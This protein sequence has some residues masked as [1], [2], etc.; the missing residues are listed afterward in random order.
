MAT[1]H[2]HEHEDPSVHS[3]LLA[4]RKTIHGYHLAMFGMAEHRYQVLLKYNLPTD[5]INTY[6]MDAQA[7]PESFYAVRNT[8]PMLLPPVGDGTLT[9]YPARLDRVTQTGNGEDRVFEPIKEG[10]T[11][12]IKEVLNFRRF[13]QEDF[14][15]HLTYLI[16]GEGDEAHIAHR[17][18][19]RP[20]FEQIIT[21]RH[22]PDGLTQD[23]LSRAVEVTIPSVPDNGHGNEPWTTRPLPNSDYKAVLHRN[24]T[25]QPITL[26]LGDERWWNITTLNA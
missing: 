20:H 18:V 23:D 15:A 13:T 17:L 4:G 10:F 11:A 8:E 19:D 16:Y 9:E 26:P 3:F 5:V 6:L 21:L 1:R 14:P 25:A 22:V 24:G 12:R 7:H 2:D